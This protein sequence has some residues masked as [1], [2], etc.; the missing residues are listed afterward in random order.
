MA[1]WTIFLADFL[2]RFLL[3]VPTKET[4]EERNSLGDVL[5]LRAP[6]NL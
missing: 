3:K 2:I 5:C 1:L 4:G 6:T